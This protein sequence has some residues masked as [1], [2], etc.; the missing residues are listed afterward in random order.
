MIAENA[1]SLFFPISPSFQLPRMSAKL[2]LEEYSCKLQSTLNPIKIPTS[3]SNSTSLPPLTPS[4]TVINPTARN[5][6][7]KRLLLHI[8]QHLRHKGELTLLHNLRNTESHLSSRPQL[9][10][11]CITCLS[12]PFIISNSIERFNIENS[13]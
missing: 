6:S 1:C 11:P 2:Y 3:T 8:L 13:C 7:I 12:N 10:I 4:A 5:P 9:P